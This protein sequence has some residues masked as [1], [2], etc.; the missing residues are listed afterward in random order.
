[1][2]I[3]YVKGFISLYKDNHILLFL[4]FVN[5]A[6]GIRFLNIEATLQPQDKLYSFRKE[7]VLLSYLL[8]I[9]S[10]IFCNNFLDF[11][12]FLYI[13]NI[14]IFYMI[15]IQLCVCLFFAV[16]TCLVII[17]FI[18]YRELISVKLFLTIVSG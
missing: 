2:T 4:R 13:C 14:E 8:E 15:S 1:M 5:M 3:D 7:V 10:L 18:S 11:T 9:V 12:F 16:F 17:F 6:Y